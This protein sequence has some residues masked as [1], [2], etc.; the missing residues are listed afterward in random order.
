[1][2]AAMIAAAVKMVEFT[3]TTITKDDYL[4]LRRRMMTRA[5]MHFLGV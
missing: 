5:K 1:M 2:A 3:T 4:R